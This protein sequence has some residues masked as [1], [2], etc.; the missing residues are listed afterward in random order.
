MTV[1]AIAQNLLP[2]EKKVRLS[3]EVKGLEMVEGGTKDVT[4]PSRG[5]ATID[6][7]VRVTNAAEAVLLGKALTDEESDALELTIPVIPFGVRMSQSRA[8]AISQ[9]TAGTDAEIEFPADAEAGSRMMDVSASPSA[10]GAVFEALEY[11]TSFPYGCTEQTMSSFLPNVVVSK[12]VQT[13]GIKT[14]FKDEVLQKQIR[15]GLD[16][17]YNFQHEDGGWG[18]WETDESDAFMTAYVVAGLSQ[19]RSAG[20]KVEEERLE[21]GQVAARGQEPRH[22]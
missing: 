8:G 19:A 12:A 22:G 3:L 11:L 10:A 9:G 2:S 15:A 14:S 7:R 1:T 21:R 17:L 13:L 20:V 18:W 4:V 6:Y 5:T 16:R